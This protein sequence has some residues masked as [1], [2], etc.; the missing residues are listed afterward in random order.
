VSL[1]RTAGRDSAQD[2]GGGPVSQEPAAPAGFA[3]RWDLDSAQMQALTAYAACLTRWA[4]TV[5]LVSRSSLPDLWTRHLADSLQLAWAGRGFAPGEARWLDIGAGAGLPGIP[6][7]IALGAVSKDDP[8]VRLVESDARKCAFLQEAVRQSG[9]PAET[10]RARIEDLGPD[11]HPADLITAR[12]VASLDQLLE[13]SAPWLARGGS[14]VF[15]K[16]RSWQEELTAAR[17]SWTFHVEQRAS[18]TDPDAALLLIKEATR[19]RPS[20]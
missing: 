12:A 5:N 14:A 3:E 20:L 18:V 15:L 1:T 4:G 17:Q 11:T 8:R 13:W 16:G 10:V 19:V 9:A 2:K 6:L 7:A